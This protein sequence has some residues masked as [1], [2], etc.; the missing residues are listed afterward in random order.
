VNHRK[1]AH[2]SQGVEEAERINGS[3][4][5]GPKTAHDF[6]IFQS[7]K[8]DTA[9]RSDL[10]KNPHVITQS[11]SSSKHQ[12]NQQNSSLL[13]LPPRQ[14]KQMHLTSNQILLRQIAGNKSSTQI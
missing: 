5:I 11:S 1:K 6:K 3:E 10:K 12:V 7:P 9:I 14:T 4:G 13:L 8:K 2:E